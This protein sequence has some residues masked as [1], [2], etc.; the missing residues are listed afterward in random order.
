MNRLFLSKRTFSQQ[1]KKLQNLWPYQSLKLTQAREVLAQLYGF[2]NAHQYHSLIEQQTISSS[3]HTEQQIHQHF[4]LLVARLAEQQNME[5][6]V[7]KYIIK[8][9]WS[10]YIASEIQQWKQFQSHFTF[11]GNLNDFLHNTTTTT[12]DYSFDGS[13]SVKDSIEAIGIPH[14]EVAQ[15]LIGDQAIDLNTKL[16]NQ[17]Q[18]SIYPANYANTHIKPCPPHKPAE[19]KFILDVHL[20]KLARSL[21][22][23]G[24]DCLYYSQD[25]IDENLAR[26]S[27]EEDRILLTRDIG[28]LKRSN[29]TYGYFV[30][31]TRAEQQLEEVLSYY[32]LKNKLAPL[33]VCLDCNGQLSSIHK[34]KVARLLPGNVASEYD[35]FKHCQQCDKV[36]WE[37]SHFDNM[38]KSLSKIAT[39]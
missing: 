38:K 9:L 25:I 36:Y 24:F 12:I 32:D 19:L 20:G 30:R 23:C 27:A 8:N 35:E 16:E 28:L 1:A 10:Q 33:S 3:K 14:T 15:V 22:M 7:S 11:Y 4:P 39:T 18:L 31:N 5:G 26:L 6:Q 17:Q 29:V 37:G 2:R 13:P 21:R 34:D